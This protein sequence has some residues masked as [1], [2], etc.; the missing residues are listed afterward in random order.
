MAVRKPIISSY[1]A[2]LVH[3]WRYARGNR[4]F[5]SSRNIP[6]LLPFIFPSGTRWSAPYYSTPLWSPSSVKM[7]C[8][9]V[10]IFNYADVGP[11]GRC[12]RGG[13]GDEGSGS[14][15]KPWER[16]EPPRPQIWMSLKMLRR[17]TPLDTK[18]QFYETPRYR[19]LQDG[20]SDLGMN[21]GEGQCLW[22]VPTIASV[23]KPVIPTSFSFVLISNLFLLS[24]WH[25]CKWKGEH[26]RG[27][28]SAYH[29]LFRCTTTTTTR[30][31]L[32]Q[33]IKIHRLQKY[34]TTDQL[35]FQNF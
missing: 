11:V 6:Q 29:S 12:R 16:E 23:Q 1:F 20:E 7:H 13:E 24:A 22:R 5:I 21:A 18:K 15:T 19:V 10:M 14:R 25:F 17:I 9:C 30:F 8:G 2:S 26:F 34:K 35:L 31:G 28:L 4:V 32:E 33:H 27:R 3:Q